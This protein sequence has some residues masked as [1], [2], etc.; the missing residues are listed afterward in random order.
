[1][2]SRLIGAGHTKLK[3]AVQDIE[4]R[5]RDIL[6]LEKVILHQTLI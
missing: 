1:M 5:H 4:E 3:N 6:N 2:Y